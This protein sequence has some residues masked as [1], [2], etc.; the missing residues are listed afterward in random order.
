[1]S[2]TK[3]TYDLELTHSKLE[4]MQLTKSLKP[5]R[6]GLY[7]RLRTCGPHNLEP[8]TD[9]QKKLQNLQQILLLVDNLQTIEVSSSWNR[10]REPSTPKQTALL[11]DNHKMIYGPN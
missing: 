2:L 6:F 8:Q 9:P 5:D 10:P 7:T 3:Y 1:M 4:Q 11:A